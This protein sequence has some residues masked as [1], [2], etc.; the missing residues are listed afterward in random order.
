MF[1]VVATDSYVEEC[2]KAKKMLE[3]FSNFASI[4]NAKKY[5]EEI[6]KYISSISLFRGFRVKVHLL[7]PYDSC[8]RDVQ[9][10]PKI[11]KDTDI[12]EARMGLNPTL[13]EC[14]MFLPKPMKS[15][16]KVLKQTVSSKESEIKMLRRVPSNLKLFGCFGRVGDLCILKNIQSGGICN[17]ECKWHGQYDLVDMDSK[18]IFFKSCSRVAKELPLFKR[19]RQGKYNHICNSSYPALNSNITYGCVR[20]EKHGYYVYRKQTE[21]ELGRQS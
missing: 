10:Y 1:K 12:S 21:L 4:K 20:D 8:N 19:A 15:N 14:L 2:V 16:W 7:S 17:L 3:T 13:M 9:V 6:T 18:A 5:K 11:I